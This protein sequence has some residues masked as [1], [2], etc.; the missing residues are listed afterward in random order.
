LEFLGANNASQRSRD[1]R[2]KDEMERVLLLPE[3]TTPTS[4]QLLEVHMAK[5]DIPWRLSA[6]IAIVEARNKAARDEK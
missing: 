4:I 3:Y 5:M 6:Q 1:V 2:T